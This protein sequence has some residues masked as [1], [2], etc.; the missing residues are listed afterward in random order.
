MSKTGYVGVKFDEKGHLQL[1]S[2]DEPMFNK[3]MFTL[4]GSRK[5]TSFHFV[6]KVFRA[7]VMKLILR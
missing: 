2:F 4:V 3:P 6:V 7:R 5:R 1:K